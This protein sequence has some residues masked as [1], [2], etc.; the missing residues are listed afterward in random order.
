[1]L[2]LTVCIGL[3]VGV[4]VPYLVLS[5]GPV[6]NTIGQVAGKDAIVVSGTRTYPTTGS[7][8]MT[9]VSEFGGAEGGVSLA[10]ALQG[11]ISGS[12]RVVPRE[13]IYPESESHAQAAQKNAEAYATSQSHAIAAALRELGMPV[14]TSVV[15]SEV[16]QG[17]PAQ[18]LLHAGDRITAVDGKRVATPAEVVAAVRA[19]PA[20]TRLTFDVVRDGAQS[21]IEVASAARADDPATAEDES[22]TP[23]VGAGVDTLYSGDFTVD[24]TIDKVGGPSAGMMFALGLLDKLTPGEL[25]AGRTIAGTGT[26]SP[27]GEVGPIGGIAQKMAGARKAGA[28]LFLAPKSNCED[29]RGH[30]PTGLVVTPVETLAQ[31]RAAVESFTLGQDLPTCG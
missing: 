11:W 8:D 7:L 14:R 2:G 9:T 20:G 6:F 22:G 18:N 4:Q 23:Y 21:T 30:V 31:A 13:T 28:E 1:M 25:T 17:A 3:G 10:Q 26:I 29:V 5:P 12:R 24:F 27:E 19:K 15:V 16:T